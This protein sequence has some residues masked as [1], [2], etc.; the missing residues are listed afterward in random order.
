M[1]LQFSRLTTTVEIRTNE[2]PQMSL[3]VSSLEAGDNGVVGKEGLSTKQYRAPITRR[4][5]ARSPILQPSPVYSLRSQVSSLRLDY[6][7]EDEDK[8]STTTSKPSEQALFSQ[9]LNWLHQEQS[10]NRSGSDGV[11]PAGVNGRLHVEE[12]RHSLGSEK[13]LALDQLETIL[14]HYAAAAR[15]QTSPVQRRRSKKHRSSRLK[16]LRRGSGSESDHYDDPVVPSVDAVLDNTKTLGYTGGG[17]TDQLT[18][19]PDQRSRHAKENSHWLTFK[20]EILRLTH[21]L[22]LKGWRKVAV[23]DSAD[24]EVNRL[25]G[26][27]TNAVY[28]V[29]PPR[30]LPPTP[31]A[32]RT[33]MRAPVRPPP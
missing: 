33:A 1:F 12:K 30:P 31:N 4:I 23:E 16:G 25:S 29:K 6:Q 32:D 26:A 9:V 14:E 15:E 24:I 17:S 7:D 5:A 3:S 28:V 18:L 8:D 20:S 11:F 21:T 19:S 2:N 13:G 22:R 27:L 10:K